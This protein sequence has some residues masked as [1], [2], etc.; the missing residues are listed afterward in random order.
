M[1]YIDLRKINPAD[2]EVT[3][4]LN[5]A[6][7]HQKALANQPNHAA[8]SEYLTQNGIWGDF[9]P[10]LKR[11]FGNKCW[12]SECSLSN[13]PGD[14]DHFHPKNRSKD[15]DNS[16]LLE[17]GYWWLAYD[18]M[19]YRLSCANCNRPY[20]EG[21]KGDIFPVKGGTTLALS[22]ERYQKNHLLLDPCNAHDVYLIGFDEEGK[23]IP[24]TNDPWQKKRVECSN[25][26]YNLDL[27]NADRKRILV[28]TRCAVLQFDSAYYA[29]TDPTAVLTMLQE[30]VSEQSEFST[31]ARQY[32]SMRIEGKPY[33]QE[34]AQFL[35]LDPA[36]N[37]TSASTPTLVG[38]TE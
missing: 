20:E 32:I 12:Y 23:V 36:Q 34:L 37:C 21:G 38:S 3:D 33:E 30:L 7:V 19:N 22:G 1:R 6:M 29:E 18:Y 11:Y 31:V 24:I 16:V 13:Q 17:D 4:W 14:V 15:V 28:L 10:I 2:P 25:K 35:G 9:K 8:R 27:F 5:K 26:F